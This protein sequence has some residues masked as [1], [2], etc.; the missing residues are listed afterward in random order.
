MIQ[1]SQ[2][3]MQLNKVT[4]KMYF[5]DPSDSFKSTLKGNPSCLLFNIDTIKEAMVNHIAPVRTDPNYT[6]ALPSKIDYVK[7][8]PYFAFRPHEVIQHTYT[9]NYTTG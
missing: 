2:L 3:M 4:Q 7:L 5:F 6:K 8:S 1:C 9:A